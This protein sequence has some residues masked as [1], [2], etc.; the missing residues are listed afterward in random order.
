M[1]A[2]L[3][4][5]KLVCYAENEFLMPCVY[6]TNRSTVY[7]YLQRGIYTPYIYLMPVAILL[8]GKMCFFSYNIFLNARL[9]ITNRNT[10]HFVLTAGHVHI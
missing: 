8:V 10:V 1:A 3:L 7:T 9:Y 5:H 6:I 4:F 2:T